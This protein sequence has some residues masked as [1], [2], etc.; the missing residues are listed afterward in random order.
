MLKPVALANAA[1]VVSAA[2]YIGCVILAYVA[3][4]LLFVI[5]KPWF[6]IYN[7]EVLKAGELI[8]IPSAA[9]GLVTMSIFIW[10][11]AYGFGALYNRFAK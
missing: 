5:T 11:W 6:H 10:I 2:L 3:S 4:D 7:V 8:S 9:V 1:A